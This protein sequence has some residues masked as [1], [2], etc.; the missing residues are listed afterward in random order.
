MDYLTMPGGREYRRK[1]I[2]SANDAATA[3]EAAAILARVAQAAL[4]RSVHPQVLARL[5][6]AR[7]AWMNHATECDAEN[8]V[9]EHCA[10][11]F[12]ASER[13][14]PDLWNWLPYEARYELLR[15]LE[16]EPI[17]VALKAQRI[18]TDFKAVIA[19]IR[20]ASTIPAGT[21][22]VGSR[23]LAGQFMSGLAVGGV[24][25]RLSSI[26]QALEALP[27]SGR[28]ARYAAAVTMLSK[29]P[30]LRVYVERSLDSLLD[31]A[32]TEW[33]E[34]DKAPQ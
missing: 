2:R 22:G 5:T 27:P 19:A 25:A 11:L 32:E 30:F 15:P 10:L 34:G 28:V 9:H 20:D 4:A 14:R 17:A 33:L 26:E 13:Q 3:R 16:E 18:A 21:S 23:P 1:A 7:D 31:Q 6:A 29:A 24:A 8:E 12:E